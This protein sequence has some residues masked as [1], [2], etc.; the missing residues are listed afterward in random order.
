MKRPATALIALVVVLAVTACTTD[1]QPRNQAPHG[2][3]AE[4]QPGSALHWHDCAAAIESTFLSKHRC[5]T[6]AVPQDHSDPDS[7]TLDL[8]VVQVW[9][10]G[11]EPRDGVATGFAANIGDPR[12][13]GGGMAAGATRL[14]GTFVELAFRGTEPSSPTLTCPEVDALATRA[15]GLPDDDPGLRTSI[16]EA[17]TACAVRLRNGGVEPAVFDTAAA[18]ADLDELRKALGVDAWWGAGSYGTQSRVM[19]RYLHDFPDR[20]EEAWLDSPWFPETDELTGGVLGTRSALAQLFT[21]CAQDAP[22]NRRY[23]DLANAW[24]RALLHTATT[25]LTGTSMTGDDEAVEVVVDDAKLLRFVR[26]SLGGEGP[27]NLTWLPRVI[28]DAASGRLNP[29]LADLVAR[30]PVFCAG[31][32]PQCLNV[33]GFALGVYLTVLCKEQLPGVDETALRQAISNEP[34]YD[35]VFARSPYVEAC[36]PWNTPGTEASPPADPNGTPLLLLPGQFDSFSRPEWSEAHSR[37]WEQTWTFT[38]PNNTHNTL[39]YDECGLSVRNAW[40]ES[41]TTAPHADLCTNPL[42]LTFH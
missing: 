8:A 5:G 40:A 6:L 9:P 23:P 1:D 28:S 12:V 31:Y 30:D 26:Y 10:V 21:A 35:Q 22:C 34:A 19:F 4:N 32:R 13:F 14:R 3:G 11:V 27:Q 33:D 29:H 20:L 39:G 38:V 16:M 7:P 37:D 25:P 18:A 15:A 17:V 41:P 24:A 36:A 2:D 42:T